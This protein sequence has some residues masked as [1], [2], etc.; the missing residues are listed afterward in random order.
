MALT[1]WSLQKHRSSKT[2]SARRWNPI[3]MNESDPEINLALISRNNAWNL[4]FGELG[5]IEFIE[6]VKFINL[7]RRF[8]LV[9]ISCLAHLRISLKTKQNIML[10]SFPFNSSLKWSCFDYFQNIPGTMHFF[11]CKDKKICR[12]LADWYQV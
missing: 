12:C 5:L 11:G 7:L 10:F 9:S 1:K 6:A 8:P 2:D 3:L 4:S